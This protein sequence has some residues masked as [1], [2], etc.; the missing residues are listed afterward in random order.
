VKL[1]PYPDTVIFGC[2]LAL[3]ASVIV[4]VHM[5]SRYSGP[6]LDNNASAGRVVFTFDDGPTP[7]TQQLVTELRHLR[8]RAILFN[9]GIRALRRPTD[10]QFERQNGMVIGDHTMWHQS[11]T[12]ASTGTRP[13]SQ[14]EAAAELSQASKALVSVGAPKPTLWRPPYGDV[15]AMDKTVGS[16]LGLRLVMPWGNPSSG[17]VDSGDWMPRITASQIVQRVEHGYRSKWAGSSARYWPGVHGGSAVSFH[18]GPAW[19]Q[20]LK[21]LPQIVEFMNRHHLGMTVRLPASVST[22]P[23]GSS[24]KE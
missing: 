2:L 18:D 5:A 10:V 15:N 4:G 22:L 13:L 24:G 9:I 12:G 6:A 20:V 23:A 19:R 21:A 14:A 3:G 16:G 8:I 11:L 17:T 1:R 7:H